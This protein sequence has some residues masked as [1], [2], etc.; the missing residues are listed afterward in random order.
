MCLQRKSEKYLDYTYHLIEWII[1]V[2][3]KIEN[4]LKITLCEDWIMRKNK[5]A[6]AESRRIIVET[7]SRLFRARGFD[8]VGVADLMQ[9]AG[10]THGAFYRHFPSKE[11]LVAEAM[12]HAFGEA[13]TRLEPQT[14]KKGPK[15]AAIP[16][17]NYLN[18]Y[19][20]VGHVTHADSGCPMA[21]VGSE[22]PHAGAH[23]SAAFETG[24]SKIVERMTEALQP[25]AP[26]PREDAL[27]LLSSLVGAI[28]IARAVGDGALRDEVIA[29]VRADPMVSRA[30]GAMSN[31][32]D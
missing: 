2:S 28:T 12:A 22:A 17:S 8:G 9:A 5:Q 32:S 4:Y 7:A 10:M 21:A 26:A 24:A 31:A 14:D 29:A 6:T 25:M 1:D 15:A 19:L 11:A 30:L 16:L 27:R 3:Y 13:V 20:S 23:V 18:S